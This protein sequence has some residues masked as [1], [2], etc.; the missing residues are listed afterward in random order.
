MNQNT[1]LKILTKAYYYE[2]LRYSIGLELFYL[3]HIR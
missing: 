2:V 1:I 3:F